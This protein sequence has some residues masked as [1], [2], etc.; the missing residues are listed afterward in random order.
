MFH[1]FN[2]KKQQYD[3][4]GIG[5]MVTDAF[6][7]LA[8]AFVE[9][10]KGA[11]GMERKNIC[12]TF[13]DKIPYK[14]VTVIP[15]VGNATNA[16]VSAAR[17]GLKSAFVT[18]IGDDRFGEDCVDVLKKEG[19]GTEFIKVNKGAKSNYHYVLMFQEER[20]ILVKHEEYEYVLPEIGEPK[21][22]YLSSMGAK[23][24]PF[25]AVLE[26]YFNEHPNVKL[27][28]Q[29]GTY[30]MKFGKE[31][32]AGIYKRADLFFCNREEA[33]RILRTE[34]NDPKKLLE[35]MHALGPKIVAITDGPAGA[36]V[37]DGGNGKAYF[38][39]IYPDPKPPVS[40]TGAGDSFSSTFTVAILLGKSVE[41]ALRWGPINSMSVVQHIGARAGLLTRPQLEKYLAVAPEGYKARE[42]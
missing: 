30:Q 37:Y 3:F 2:N 21:C 38:M 6:I 24:L 11:D 13:G 33:Q 28:F 17:L 35:M 12:M 41:E 5:D 8:E 39:P 36:Y 27:V 34:E 23:S 19:V 42:I 18:N 9:D 1:F 26:K 4:I 40:R 7:D 20:T 31:A 10:T 25:H 32:L 22:V 15:A 14:S 29:P 16:S